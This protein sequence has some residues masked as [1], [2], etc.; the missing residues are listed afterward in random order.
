M[1]KAIG[2]ILSID[3]F[4]Q[5]CVVI[6]GM[7]ISP[8]LEDHMK[9]IGIDQS[10]SKRPSFEHTF[11]NNIKK[12]YQHE[13]KCDDQQNLKDILDAAMVSTLEE[14]TDVSLGFHITQTT[15]KPPRARKSLCLFTNIFDVK[16]ITEIC[17]ITQSHKVGD[18]LWTNKKRKGHSKINDQIKR[19]MY[20]WITRHP[21]AVQSPI[22]NK[23]LKVIFNYQKE[24]QLDLK[25]LLQVSIC[26]NK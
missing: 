9:T 20:V 4:E 13:G 25:M 17:R 8:R 23:C 10:L 14:V 6:K 15:V 21:Q 3:T 11:L 22:Y 18:I 24:P 2:Y 1:N 26:R 16:K 7:L 19:N 12:I 5:Q